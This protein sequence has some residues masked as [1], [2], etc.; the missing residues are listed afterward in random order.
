[1][2]DIWQSRAAQQVQNVG[3]VLEVEAPRI[4]GVTQL[5]SYY[6]S[7]LGPPVAATASSTSSLVSVVG[8]LNAYLGGN[9][10]LDVTMRR[11]PT[12][13][14]AVGRMSASTDEGHADPD[15]QL[16][17]LL[18]ADAPVRQMADAADWKAL[19]A[20]KIA[21]TSAGTNGASARELI[22][23][24]GV[25]GDLSRY[26]AAFQ[27]RPRASAPAQV[28]PRLLPREV[29]TFM[30]R[31]DYSH[32]AD[33]RAAAGERAED[34]AARQIADLVGGFTSLPEA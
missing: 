3:E 5:N 13:R 21:P 26:A 19:A 16:S 14:S 15:A 6:Q 2:F 32:A 18:A 29:G 23:D 33:P 11:Y 10:D 34:S 4:T 24:R 28:P 20:W 9:A 1:M 12:S 27:A 8:E 30:E 17:G 25:S 22:A 31:S 7:V